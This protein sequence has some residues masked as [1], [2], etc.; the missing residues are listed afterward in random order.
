MEISRVS[1]KGQVTI[2]V[3]FRKKLGIKEGDKVVFIEIGNNILIVNSNRLA[4][5][6][7]QEGMA[8]EAERVGIKNEQDVVDLVKQV[9]EQ[10]W[11]EENAGNAGH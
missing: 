7:F 4:F 6:E 8:G 1:S 10:M 3:E 11:R 5:K 9:R 2:P